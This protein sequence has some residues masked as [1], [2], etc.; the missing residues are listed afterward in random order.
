MIKWTD[1]TVTPKR[2]AQELIMDAVAVARGYWGENSS[3]TFEDMTERE[4]TLVDEQ[5]EKLGD[6]VARM[7]GFEDSWVG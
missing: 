5:L 1:E 2:L 4:R 6:R 7:M 3:V